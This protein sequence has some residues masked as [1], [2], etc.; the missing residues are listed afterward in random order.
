MIFPIKKGSIRSSDRKNRMHE[1]Q[2]NISQCVLQSECFQQNKPIFYY[3]ITAT[4][5]TNHRQCYGTF[6]LHRASPNQTHSFI[7]QVKLSIL[8]KKPREKKYQIF[9]GISNI[10]ADLCKLVA[11]Q[12]HSTFFDI[13]AFDL[14]RISNI[15]HP[16]PYSVSFELSASY[17]PPSILYSSTFSILY[18]DYC[19]FGTLSTMIPCFQ[20]KYQPDN[21]CLTSWVSHASTTNWSM[22]IP[23]RLIWASNRGATFQI[24]S[25]HFVSA[26]NMEFLVCFFF[27]SINCSINWLWF[28]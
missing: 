8:S 7:F 21:I 15:M 23:S 9:M 1:Q 20:H 10:T 11:G 19:T 17:M 28:I 16:C 5:G 13:A 18:R 24:E 26:C 6:I 14:E 25:L 12:S 22:H 3:G 4:A 2:W 27:F